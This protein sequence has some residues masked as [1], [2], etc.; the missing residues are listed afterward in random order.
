MGNPGFFGLNVKLNPQKTWLIKPTPLALQCPKGYSSQSV[1]AFQR[2]TFFLRS[3]T[4]YSMTTA[5]PLA[6]AIKSD[7]FLE[8][9][10]S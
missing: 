8:P 6:E 3:A 10:L 7:L 9:M 5:V 1:L 4:N 2:Q